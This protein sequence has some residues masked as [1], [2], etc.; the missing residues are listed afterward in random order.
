SDT[1]FNFQLPT[2]IFRL[3]RYRRGFRQRAIRFVSW[4]GRPSFST[5]KQQEEERILIR[6]TTLPETWKQC[7]TR[8]E[9]TSLSQQEQGE[10]LRFYIDR[11]RFHKYNPT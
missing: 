3:D 5:K 10:L 9:L 11:L 6:G 8:E 2:D 4:F 1:G 7:K